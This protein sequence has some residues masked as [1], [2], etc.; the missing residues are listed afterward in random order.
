MFSL[1]FDEVTRVQL[2]Q[3]TQLLSTV[4]AL[5]ESAGENTKHAAENL[6][7]QLQKRKKMMKTSMNVDA[8]YKYDIMIS[9]SHVDKALCDSIHDKLV[10]DGYR[11][12]IDHEQM[13]GETVEAMATAIENAEFVLICMSHSYKQSAYCQ[14]E[15]HYAF[16]RRCRLIP[17]IMIS[18][19][20]PD[21]WL[22]ILV[23]GKIYVDVSKLEFDSA[24]TR[25]K[26]IIEQHRQLDVKNKQYTETENQSL[27]TVTHAHTSHTIT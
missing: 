12:W 1:A 14:M 23:S 16:E 22:G 4:E 21:G 20:K 18:R 24:Y 2:A 15:E 19:Y 8:D 27:K 6:L 3:D 9:Y 13:H 11:V 5:I 17:L 10:K 26:Y 25:L 7:W